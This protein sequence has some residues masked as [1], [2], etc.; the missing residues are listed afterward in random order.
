MAPPRVHVATS[1]EQKKR[2]TQAQKHEVEQDVLSK[3]K[4][5]RKTAQKS[6]RKSKSKSKTMGKSKTQEEEHEQAQ[7]HEP[8][9][10]GRRASRARRNKQNSLN[11]PTTACGESVFEIVELGSCLA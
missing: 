1:G 10:E 2:Q 11:P 9:T 5:M 3:R 8:W 7:G 4:S 6:K